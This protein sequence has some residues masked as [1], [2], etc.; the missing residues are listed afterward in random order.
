M[1]VSIKRKPVLT[2]HSLIIS[3]YKL[4]AAFST[5][6][7]IRRYNIKLTEYYEISFRLTSS[8][9]ADKEREEERVG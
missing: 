8:R 2:K 6:K 7:E 3:I 5:M 4:T 9:R 1:L